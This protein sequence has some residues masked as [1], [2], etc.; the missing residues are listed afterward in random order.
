MET[1]DA[2]KDVATDAAATVAPNSV[3]P[4]EESAA[5]KPSE[6]TNADIVARLD[7]LIEVMTPP[8]TAAPEEDPVEEV[9]D[10]PGNNEVVTDSSPASPPWT[11][12]KFGH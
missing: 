4:S 1:E 10:A 2:T 3:T 11:H 6:P 9:I 12:R 5:S 7:K 8:A